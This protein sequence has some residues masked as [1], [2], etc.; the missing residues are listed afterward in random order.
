MTR[1][2]SLR[3]QFGRCS[4]RSFFE[5]A[6]EVLR[7]NQALFEGFVEHQVGWD[8]AEEVGFPQDTGIGPG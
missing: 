6:L 7:A 5:P 8:Q 4:V 2:G 1:R 3:F